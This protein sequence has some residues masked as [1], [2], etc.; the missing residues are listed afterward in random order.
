[1]IPIIG[2]HGPIGS[3]KD[4]LAS[5]LTASGFRALKHATPLYTM[6]HALDPV[7]M[8]GMAH[9]DKDG[10]V[11]N[12]A[13]LGTR[14]N[15]L[16]KLGTEFCRDM[17]NGDFFSI[18]MQETILDSVANAP[19]LA[20]VISDVRFENEAT[21]IRKLGG[22]IVHLKPDWDCPRTG[23]ASDAGLEFKVGDSI[24]ELEYG[25]ADKGYKQLMAIIQEEYSSASVRTRVSI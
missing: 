25:R 7:F 10:Y 4:T 9:K 3:G 11:L 23:H 18:L 13:S 16:E 12:N 6:A 5:M 24:L 20:I 17:I 19:S 22:H 15:F 14:R 21:T 8:P 1:M 2:L